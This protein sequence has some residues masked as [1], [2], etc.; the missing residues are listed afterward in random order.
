MIKLVIFDFDDTLTDNNY[1]D[2]QA[3]L[4]PCTKLGLSSPTLQTITKYRKKGF[5]AKKIISK[6]LKPNDRKLYL[7]KFLEYK[8][9]FLNS[10]NSLQYLKIKKKYKGI[11]RIFKKSENKMCN[12]YC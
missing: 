6:F 11:I 3:F 10:K 4:V 1:L 2:Y 5:I 12:L 8:K 9:K 7:N